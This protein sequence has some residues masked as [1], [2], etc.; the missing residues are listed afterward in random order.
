[1]RTFTRSEEDLSYPRAILIFVIAGLACAPLWAQYH[2]GDGSSEH[3]FEIAEPNQLIY[4]SQHPEDWNKNFLLTADINMNLAEPNTFTTALIAPDTD[5]SNY[6]FQGTCFTGSFDGAGYNI[7][8]L[9]INSNGIGEDYLGLFGCI[10]SGGKIK[11]L[12][13]ENF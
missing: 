7:I 9:T 2:D 8:G 3:P 13:M 11:N 5:N 4:M 12:S 10:D 1:M 6:S